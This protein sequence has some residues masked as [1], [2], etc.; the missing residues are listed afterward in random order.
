[1]IAVDDLLMDSWMAL[2]DSVISVPV[3][4][5]GSVP[6]SETGNYV[7]LR[8]ESNSSDDTKQSFRT[9]EIIITDIVT[10]FK[11]ATDRS[12]SSGIDN[13]IK[14]LIKTSPGFHG[15]AT[16]TGI[17]ILNV[18]METSSGFEEVSSGKKYYRKIVRYRNRIVQ[19]T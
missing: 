16:Q 7:E 2:L 6:E 13:E 10:S 17:Q 14:T 1:M 19:T 3:Y 18:V 5:E 15:L 9:D 4:K 11:L 8:W 12:I